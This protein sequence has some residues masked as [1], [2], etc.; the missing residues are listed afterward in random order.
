MGCEGYL[1]LRAKV[2]SKEQAEL[3]KLNI[4]NESILN[5]Y[6]PLPTLAVNEL[7]FAP[8]NGY[9]RGSI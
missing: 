2:A 5:T 9:W 7:K 8:D 3:I 6:V 1:P 4:L